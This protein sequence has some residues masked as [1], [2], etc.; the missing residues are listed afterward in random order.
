MSGLANVGYFL[1][2]IFF[3]IVTFVLWIR[4]AFRYFRISPL[5][6]LHR[7]ITALTA[8][9]V[10]PIENILPKQTHRRS[11]YDIA[12]IVVLL[13]CELMKFTIMSYLFLSKMMPAWLLGLYVFGDFIVQPCNIIFYAIL[14]RVIMSFINQK[15]HNPLADTL[16]AVTDPFLMPIQKHV[17]IVGGLDISPFLALILLKSIMIFITASIPLHLI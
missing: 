15:W 4:I 1:F 10:Q 8:F 17:P 13:F 3:S 12:S 16:K 5:N 11:R 6:S 9:I 14:I 7:N 2:S